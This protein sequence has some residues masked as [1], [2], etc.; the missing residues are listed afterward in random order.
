VIALRS[1]GWADIKSD[2]RVSMFALQIMAEE[3]VGNAL[4]EQEAYEQSQ[5]NR[6]RRYVH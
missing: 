4:R 6:L 2:W 5:L 3:T 1:G